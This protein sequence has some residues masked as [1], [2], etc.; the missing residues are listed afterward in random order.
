MKRK[1]LFILKSFFGLIITASITIV[2]CKKKDTTLVAEDKS[3][4]E[5]AS[6]SDAEAEFAYNDVY[7]NVMG[8]NGYGIG[9]GPVGIFG[10]ASQDVNNSDPNTLRTDSLPPCVNITVTPL[11]PTAFPKT[12]TVDF[13]TAGCPGPGGHF[14]RGKIIT[15]YT[16]PMS[17]AGNSATTTF[18]NHYIDSIKVEGL[19]KI[20]NQSSGT[21]KSYNV[22]VT[23][24]KLTKP[25]GNY[26][27]HNK[28]KTHTQI[29]GVLT[30]NIPVDD[31][32]E[33]T[34]TSSGEYKI[35]TIIK[36]WN[37]T[38][39]QALVKRFTCPWFLTGKKTVTRPNGVN[40]YLD[41]APV[42]NGQCDN[43]ASLTINGNTTIIN[44]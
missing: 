3:F 30:Q 36:N 38:I 7:D 41:Y 21:N 34:G 17:V 22:Q 20:T 43:K 18:D 40:A 44:L 37:V 5:N 15:V 6:L 16:G 25:N 23:N 10:G 2:A 19:H 11:L 9:V 13:G 4:I 42:N 35:G 12:V 1:N 27:L 31:V 28:N 14:R 8:Y 33:I 26:V 24:G 32:F 39:T 29:A